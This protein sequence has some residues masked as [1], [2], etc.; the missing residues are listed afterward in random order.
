[1]ILGSL[2]SGVG[3]FE[4][5]LLWSGLVD[6]VAWQVEIDPF[7]RAVLARHYPSGGSVASAGHAV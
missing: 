1:M 7:C 2:F 6:S 3:L 5:G 4:L